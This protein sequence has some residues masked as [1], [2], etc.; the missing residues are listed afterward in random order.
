M[1]NEQIIQEATEAIEKNLNAGCYVGDLLRI[2]KEQ[3]AEIISIT[4]EYNDMLEQRNKVEEAL[5]IKTMDVNSLTSERDALQEMVAE[6]KSEKERLEYVLMAVMHSVD[7]WL[8]GDELKQDEANRACTMREKTLKITEKL[9]KKI[10][11]LQ[12]ANQ[13]SWVAIEKKKAE[14]ERLKNAYKQCAWERDV[15]SEDINAIKSEAYR[16]F[17]EILRT[18]NSTVEN[19]LNKL[20]SNN[21]GRYDHYTDSFV[22]ETAESNE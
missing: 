15:F 12:K 16:E 21:M 14:I 10:D 6:Q 11:G 22:K 13:E 7:K 4:E 18:T 8:E 2:V 3:Q 20:L 9:H 5:E 19:V 17:A 1:N